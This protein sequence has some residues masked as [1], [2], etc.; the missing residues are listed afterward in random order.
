MSRLIMG[1]FICFVFSCTVPR[2]NSIAHTSL[3]DLSLQKGKWF[4]NYVAIDGKPWN[5][6]SDYTENE[7]KKCLNDSLFKSYGS[8]NAIYAI[9]ELN[10]NNYKGYT[11]LLRVS[12][13]VDYLI[14]I[15]GKIESDN[16]SALNINPNPHHSISVVSVT[17]TAYEVQTDHIIYSETVS[18]SIDL[19]HNKEDVVF[20][21]STQSML[22]KCL[23]KALQKF[24]RNGGCN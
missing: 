3:Y 22:K 16:V 5:E 21:K 13:T 2:Y 17:L 7:L 23:E 15:S 18:G 20:A 12:K 6:F 9:P 14:Q 8:K 1:L 11:S 4:V 10:S 24:K 19:E